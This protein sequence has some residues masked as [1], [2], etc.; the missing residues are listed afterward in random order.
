MRNDN[1]VCIE[2][3][4]RF[5]GLDEVNEHVKSYKHFKFRSLK[6]CADLLFA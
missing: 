4:K 3:K 1:Y 5:I 2:C 6:Y